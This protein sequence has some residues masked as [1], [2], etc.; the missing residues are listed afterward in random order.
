APGASRP[1]GR[2][3]SGEATEKTAG[4]KI[5]PAHRGGFAPNLQALLLFRVLQGL[6]GGGMVPVA[7]SILAD[8]FPPEKRGQAFALFGV[9]AQNAVDIG[10]GLPIR[11]GD[12]VSVR[13][14]T[15]TLGQEFERVDGRQAVSRGQCD[16]RIAYC[17]ACRMQSA[18]R[19]TT[20]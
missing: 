14:E 20:S 10:R 15:T 4:A 9:A 3:T 18:P 12:N 8:S 17:A 1:N 7:Q 6:G 5:P 11:I 16:D 2:G 13:D 19:S